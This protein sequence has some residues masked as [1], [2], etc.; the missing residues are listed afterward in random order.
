MKQHNI[1]G[2]EKIHRKNREFIG[3][4]L[5]SRNDWLILF[6]IQFYLVIFGWQQPSAANSI[7]TYYHTGLS[8][9]HTLNETSTYIATKWHSKNLLKCILYCIHIVF[10]SLTNGKI[11][12]FFSE[13]Y[14]YRNDLPVCKLKFCQ[15]NQISSDWQ[16]WIH[17]NF[18]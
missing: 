5:S 4:L 12:H 6:S 17:C 1:F 18:M 16:T 3:V 7:Q 9:S 8:L 15:I 10:Y 14:S 11:V 2:E 13:R